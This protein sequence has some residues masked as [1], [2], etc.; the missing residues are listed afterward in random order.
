MRYYK[1]Q[2][3]LIGFHKSY[4]GIFVM[5]FVPFTFPSL[6]AQTSDSAIVNT[7]RGEGISFSHNNSVT[8]L[9]RDRKSVV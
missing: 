1:E 8:L 4:F 2:K 5:L 7:L 9:M 3:R 6:H